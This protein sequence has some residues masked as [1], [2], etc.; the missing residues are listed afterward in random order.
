[1][2]QFRLSPSGNGR[3]ISC[4]A[5]GAFVGSVPLLKRTSRNG[6]EVW[7]PRDCEE[8]C[9]DLG[10]RYGVPIDVSSKTGGLTAVARALSANDIARAQ[11]ISLQLQ[12]PE[13][14]VLAKQAPR[15]EMIEFVRE[16]FRSGLIKA[17]WDVR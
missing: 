8:L 16:L 15:G 17:R 6:R 9:E 10:A 5:S 12:F 7:E 11:I 1:M 2:R 3:G 14:P 13:P 4:D